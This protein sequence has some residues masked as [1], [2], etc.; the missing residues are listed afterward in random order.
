MSERV[1]K[2]EPDAD[3]SFKSCNDCIYADES[4]EVCRAKQCVHA[5]SRLAECYRPR[6]KNKSMTHEGLV[7]TAWSQTVAAVNDYRKSIDIE[8][9][10]EYA[11]RMR[12]IEKSQRGRL[13]RIGYA[14][15]RWENRLG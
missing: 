3:R 5:F 15:W 10:I 4:A 1:F 6:S 14:M 2:V 9:D 13:M 12:R 7:Y 11:C 8:S